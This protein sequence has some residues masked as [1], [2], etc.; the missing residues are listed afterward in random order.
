MTPATRT[1]PRTETRNTSRNTSR[2]DTRHSPGRIQD[3]ESVLENFEQVH[4]EWVEA[5]NR[6]DPDSTYWDAVELLIDTFDEGDMPSAMRKMNELVQQLSAELVA[7]DH[8]DDQETQVPEESFFGAVEAIFSA[9]KH[10][11]MDS[12]PRRIESIK[13]LMEQKVTMEQIARMYGFVD[14]FERPEV[15]KVR[16]E[17]DKPGTHVN[18]NWVNPAEKKR[19]RQL[20]DQQQRREDAVSN[21]MR[22]KLGKSRAPCPETCQQLWMEGVSAEQAAKMLGRP[23]REI[24]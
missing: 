6:P 11:V 19:L 15:W 10:A 23:L 21:G 20:E 12:E 14:R 13:D 18:E 1:T 4:I 7:F 5:D 17:L 2:G 24:D 9:R 3:L 22:R 16:E 8:R